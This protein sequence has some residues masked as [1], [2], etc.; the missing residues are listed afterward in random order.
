MM[1]IVTIVSSSETMITMKAMISIRE[2]VTVVTTVSY[3]ETMMRMK[4][5]NAKC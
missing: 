2:M 4:V 1:T 5:Q 3:S